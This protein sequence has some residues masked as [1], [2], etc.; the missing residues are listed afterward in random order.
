MPPAD[1]NALQAFGLIGV[2]ALLIPLLMVA[3]ADLLDAFEGIVRRRQR[4]R[5]R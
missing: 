4:R 2:A 3:I 5:R 1:I